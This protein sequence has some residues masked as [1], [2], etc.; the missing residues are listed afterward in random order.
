MAIIDNELEFAVAENN[1]NL[2]KK[3]ILQGANVNSTLSIG[4]YPPLVIAAKFGFYD[5]AK[6]LIDNGAD[7]HLLFNPG[8]GPVHSQTVIAIASLYN[9]LDIIKLFV[10]RGCNINF[11]N[12]EGMTAIII[13]ASKGYIDQ[14]MYLLING[15]SV[16][17]KVKSFFV[18]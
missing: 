13:A 10:E 5:M 7:I 14:L 6:F 16:N 17:H 9:R 1:I 15:A 11:S 2:A 4:C 8:I 12:S 18:V 3:L